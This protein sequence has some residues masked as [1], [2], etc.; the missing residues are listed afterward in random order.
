[1]K[2]LQ[3]I[4]KSVFFH[5]ALRCLSKTT[6]DRN[7][8]F[9]NLHLGETCYIFG[10]GE[11]LKSMDF[12]NFNDKVSI[13]CNSLFLHKDF[14][15]LDCRYYQILPPLFFLPYFKFYKKWQRNNISSIYRKKIKI[16]NKTNYFTS[17]YNKFII[18]SPNIYYEHH[19][20]V[21]KASLE[22]YELHKTFSFMAGA[23]DAMIGMAIYMGFKKAILVGVDYTF[24]ESV[25]HHFFEKGRGTAKNEELFNKVF[26]DHVKDKIDLFTM[27]LENNKSE[28]LKCISYTDYTKKPERY[29]EN[30][31][32]IDKEDLDKL[33]NMGLYKIW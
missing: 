11:S 13:G 14:N 4:K 24:S 30:I 33:D 3:A 17:I 25:S 16:F 2:I 22:N 5:K 21:S 15:E 10:N 31:D 19:F 29:Q 18:R 28:S 26:F 12:K 32:C 23:T 7:I 20:G 6:L 9:K 1:M 8:K 27:T